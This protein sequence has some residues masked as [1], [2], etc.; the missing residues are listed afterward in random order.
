MPERSGTELCWE[1]KKGS[2]KRDLGKKKLSSK[3]GKDMGFRF[4]FLTRP[5]ST[6][7]MF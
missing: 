1:G 7:K 6:I 3:G 4:S 2:K 5:M